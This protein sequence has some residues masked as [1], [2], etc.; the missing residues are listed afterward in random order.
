MGDDYVAVFIPGGHGPVIDLHL[1][2]S[3]G[4]ILRMAHDQELT[5]ISLCHGPNALRSAALGGDFPYSGYK[6]RIFPDMADDWSP[7]VGYLPGYITDAMKAEANLKALG[8]EV[9]NTEMDDS[10]SVDRELVTGASQMAAQKLAVAALEVLQTK[11]DFE[12]VT[13]NP[14]L[15]S[16]RTE[17][18]TDSYIPST[19][20]LNISTPAMVGFEELTVNR[21]YNGTLKILVLATSEWLLE[22]MNG[23]QTVFFN[24]GHHTTEMFVPLHHFSRSGFDF[25][26]AT[27]EGNEIALE[28]WTFD[29]AV[30]YEDVIQA[31]RDSVSDRL[32]TPQ[33]FDNITN[34]DAYAAVFIPGGHGP[35][36]DLHLH[37]SL[38]RILRMAHDQ[39]LTTISLCHGHNALRSAALGGDFPYSGYNIRIFPDMADDWSP[40]VGYLPGY[41][42]DAMKAEAN[43]KALGVEVENTEMDDSVSVDRELVTG[44]SQMA[45]QKLAVA[46]LEVLQTKFDFEVAAEVVAMNMD[47]QLAPKRTE[48][49]TDSYIP[50]TYALNISTPA[51]VGFE[52][53]TVNRPYNGTLKILVLATSEWLLEVMNG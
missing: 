16:K 11:F 48:N 23:S 7:T 53:L 47:P 33:K 34:L 17:N 8:V 18:E 50:S 6:I 29:L 30:G 15:A 40:S 26:F 41:I 35:V 21:P 12:V 19:Y 5:T 9:E 32:A 38:G 2:E 39:E 14:Q 31:M 13:M 3:L 20:A 22:V 25:D 37:E 28:E 1:Y 44:A 49:E 42:T 45:A 24:T 10:V 52:E 43:L 36:I 27:Q 46:A 51:M 4:R